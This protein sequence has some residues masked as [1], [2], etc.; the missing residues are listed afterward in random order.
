MSYY[1]PGEEAAF[2]NCLQYIPGILSVKGLGRELHIQIRSTRLSRSSILELVALY[3]RYQ[4]KLRELSMF[5]TPANKAWLEPMLV[6]PNDR[7]KRSR[8]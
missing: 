3:R 2:F 7:Q 1:A 6:P 8:G 5:S 4:G